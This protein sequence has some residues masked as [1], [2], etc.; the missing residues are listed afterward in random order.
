MQSDPDVAYVHFA[1][2]LGF[3]PTERADEVLRERSACAGPGDDV[4]RE[5]AA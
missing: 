2:A 3:L 5:G 1:T 4:P